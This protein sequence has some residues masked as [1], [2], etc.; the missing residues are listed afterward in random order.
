MA[1]QAENRQR[2]IGDRLLTVGD[3]ARLL[4]VKTG[5]IYQHSRQGCRNRLPGF[6]IGKYLRFRAGDVD[7][8]LK[9]RA[10]A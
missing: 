2:D 6:R 1:T 3:V 5:W 8:W 7:K 4:G 10:A 9:Q